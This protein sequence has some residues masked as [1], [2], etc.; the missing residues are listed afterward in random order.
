M[1]NRSKKVI[2]LTRGQ[3]LKWTYVR[4]LLIIL[5]VFNVLM[6]P[7]LPAPDYQRL[8]ALIL[9]NMTGIKEVL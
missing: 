2:E 3:C 4:A 5:I 7:R 8:E 6:P 1:I 9:Q